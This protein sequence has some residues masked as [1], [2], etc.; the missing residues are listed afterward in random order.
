MHLLVA[1]RIVEV[2]RLVQRWNLYLWA[3]K[4]SGFWLPFVGGK[5]GCELRGDP[6]GLVPGVVF[7]LYWKGCVCGSVLFVQ[8]VQV[9][10][11][12]GYRSDEVQLFVVVVVV[13]WELCSCINLKLVQSICRSD[14]ISRML[15]VSW[16]VLIPIPFVPL[17]LVGF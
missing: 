8:E 3:T 6:N 10:I 12:C 7:V 4:R 14:R 15:N 16:Q 9:V 17:S 11:S 1:H 2:P 13:V 5:C